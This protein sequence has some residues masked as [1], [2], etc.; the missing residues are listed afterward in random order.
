[1]GAGDNRLMEMVD[2]KARLAGSN[3]M[4]L[5]LFSLG[6]SEVFGINVFKVREVCETIPI[7]RTP[8]VPRGVEGII[9]LRG[10]ILPVI[11]L[12][13]TINMQVD[14]PRTKLLITEFSSHTQAFLV[15]DVDR[16]VRIDW[17]KVKSPQSM[18][19]NNTSFMT[20]LTE[21]A[22]GKLVS[23][24]DVEQILASVIGEDKIPSE[25]QQVDADIKAN[26]FFAD[27]S[28]LARKKITEVLDRMGL[29]HQHATNGADAWDKLK[30]IAARA[31][32]EKLPL[33]LMLGMI[34]VDAEMPE[35]DGYVLT[36]HIKSDPRFAKIP[37]VMHSSL[38]SVANKKLGQQ[39]GVD[40]YVAKFHPSE[41]ASMIAAQLTH[42]KARKGA[43]EA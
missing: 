27:D 9:S 2:E 30:G 3:K 39:V 11:D 13:T 25:I 18:P 23:I 29:P 38:S 21:L 6:G 5:L 7:T 8:N 40:A 32:A 35:M 24:L 12:A 10:A 14:A 19:S 17:D 16:I 22:D 20:A 37:V 41:L 1:M 43:N 4:E 36:R 42:I 15:A 31:E 28:S 26:V 33:D 34:L